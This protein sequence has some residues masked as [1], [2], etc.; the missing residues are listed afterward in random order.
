M[1]CFCLIHIGALLIGPPGTGKTLLAKAIA[2]EADVPFFFVSGSEFDEMFVG[3]GAARIRKLFG[4]IIS[5]SLSHRTCKFNIHCSC[6]LFDLLIY[7]TLTFFI[8]LVN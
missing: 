3:V 8:Q 7:T 6:L 5:I 2:G 1:Y 4:I